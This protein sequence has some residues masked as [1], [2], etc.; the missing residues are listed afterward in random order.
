MAFE[1]L[2]KGISNPALLS[3]LNLA[4]V[5][6][7]VYSLLARTKLVTEAN[8]PTNALNK[9]A[10]AKVCAI[11]QSKAYYILLPLLRGD[12]LAVMKRGR[13][14][15]PSQKAKNAS[16]SEYRNATGLEALFG[17]L[18]L[19]DDEERMMELFNICWDGIYNA[20]EK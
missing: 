12:E 5:G 2:K 11:A 20:E 4:Y 16:F 9:E 1:Q 3:P 18:F 14:A 7:G 6:D 19:K 13:N 8:R 10:N 17:Y 15:N